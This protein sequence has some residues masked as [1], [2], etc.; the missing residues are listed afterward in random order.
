MN[1]ETQNFG[2][3]LQNF[4][5]KNSVQIIKDLT[6]HEKSFD[7]I[8]ADPAWDYY[9]A[10]NKHGAAGKHYDLISQDDLNTLPI[11]N[12]LKSKNSVVFI[13]TTSPMLERA[14][15]TL[16]SWGLYY[17]GVAF[18]W[19][20]TTITGVPIKARGV[21]PSIVKSISEFCL[22]ASPMRTGRPLALQDESIP[23]QLVEYVEENTIL[24]QPKTHSA[25]PDIYSYIER[26]YPDAS[27]LELFAR[28][29][30][31]GWTSWGNE[32]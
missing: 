22:A 24:A 14:F 17:R 5:D 1:P 30:R 31:A 13:W 18:N 21:R 28:N 11:Y 12:L 8:I 10:K 23:Q 27:K 29:V 9:G 7:V 32:L 15:E 3:H 16:D 20:K 2:D 4:L 25:K 19:V 6:K 26:M